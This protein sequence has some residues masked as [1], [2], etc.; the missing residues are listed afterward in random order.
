MS[1]DIHKLTNVAEVS[2]GKITARCPACAAEGKDNQGNHLVI[3]PN[4]RFGC[5]KFEGDSGHRKKVYAL[6]GKEKNR[7][8]LLLPKIQ[9]KPYVPPPA[10]ILMDLSQYP[11]FSAD[12]VRKWEP[13]KHSS[14]AIPAELGEVP[15]SK[16]TSTPARRPNPYENW[17]FSKPCPEGVKGPKETIQPLTPPLKAPDEPYPLPPNPMKK[18]LN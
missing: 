7:V 13:D 17:A 14:A 10:E 2:D 18:R 3:Y 12:A 1:L 5:V 8:P 15:K 11:F 16:G 4:G 6:A 9:V